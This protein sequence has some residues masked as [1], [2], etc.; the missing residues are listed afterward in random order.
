MRS[1]GRDARSTGHKDS[2]RTVIVLLHR[3]LAPE[4]AQLSGVPTASL[5]TA[6]RTITL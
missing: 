2:A 3:D 6:E 4:S 1:T 5:A